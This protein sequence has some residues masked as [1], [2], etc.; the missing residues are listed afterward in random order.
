MG[1]EMCIR[2]RVEEGDLIEVNIPNRVLRIVG[3]AGEKKTEE[4][5]QEILK[6][7]KK[8]WT[9]KPLKY[10]KGVLKIFSEHAVSPMKGGY[11]K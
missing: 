8:N 3:I 10:D 4:E 2:D 1:S 6:E 11:M 5:I 9:P 7:R